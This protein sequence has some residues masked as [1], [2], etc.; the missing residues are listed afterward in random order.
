M[1]RALSLNNYGVFRDALAVT[2]NDST[3]LTVPCAS[4]YVGTQGTMVV[5]TLDL[6]TST[7]ANAFGIIPVACSRVISTGTTAQNILALY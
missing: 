5:I 2:P 4:L 1:A 6:T 3:D 7:F